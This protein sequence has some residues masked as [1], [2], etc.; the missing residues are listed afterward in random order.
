VARG[1]AGR[2]RNGELQLESDHIWLQRAQCLIEQFLTGLVACKDGYGSFLHAAMVAAVTIR[3]PMVRCK[4][5]DINRTS[6][7][8][9]CEVKSLVALPAKTN[10]KARDGDLGT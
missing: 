7:K 3:P 1:W 2:D 9:T 5:S 10:L 8:I 6:R 4:R